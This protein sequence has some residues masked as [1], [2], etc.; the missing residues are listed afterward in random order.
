MRKYL[1]TILLVLAFSASAYGAEKLLAVT[2]VLKKVDSAKHTSAEIKEYYKSIKGKEAEGRG[3]V[4]D[5]LKGR[6]DRHRV[7]ILTAAGKPKKGYDVVL[8]TEMNAP[9]QL[10]KGQTIKFKGEIGRISSFRGTSVDI[11]GGYEKAK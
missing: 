7:T 4:I 10:K 2:E 8:Y 11:H 1:F 5:V 6:R 3:K 9:A